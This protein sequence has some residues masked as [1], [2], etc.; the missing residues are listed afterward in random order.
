MLKQVLRVKQV[1]SVT[2]HYMPLR[3]KTFV[4]W[5]L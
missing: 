4:I 5:V 1:L 2:W 3:H